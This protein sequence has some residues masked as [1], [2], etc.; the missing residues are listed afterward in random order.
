MFQGFYVGTE[1]GGGSSGIC[2]VR[3]HFECCGVF[4]FLIFLILFF[5]FL[6]VLVLLSLSLSASVAPMLPPCRFVGWSPCLF[7]AGGGVSEIDMVLL[8]FSAFFALYPVFWLIIIMICL[9][10]VS[11]WVILL[12]DVGPWPDHRQWSVQMCFGC[13]LGGSHRV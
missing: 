6:P 4:C 7:V 13:N 2:R 10:C 12:V 8:G 9:R 5:D 1:S 3:G 11:S